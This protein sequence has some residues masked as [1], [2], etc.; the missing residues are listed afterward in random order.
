M[1]DEYA[2]ALDKLERM[3]A[4]GEVT[5]G[6][7]QTKRQALLAE[8]QQKQRPA[9]ARWAPAV[10]VGALVVIVLLMILGRVFGS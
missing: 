8:A 6:Y 7:Y 10:I 2:D 5:D 3:H 4:T 9:M 1:A